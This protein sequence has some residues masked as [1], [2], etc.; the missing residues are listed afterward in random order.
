MNLKSHHCLK[1]AMLQLF[2]IGYLEI[3]M[4]QLF[5][6]GYLKIVMLQLFEL[7]VGQEK[8]KQ[9]NKKQKQKPPDNVY[10][11]FRTNFN[12]RTS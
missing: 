11:H 6:I 7:F 4:L 1:M 2:E 8:Q 5:E 3:A 9:K 10:F 12:Q